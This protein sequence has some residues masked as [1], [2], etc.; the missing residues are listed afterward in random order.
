MD[1]KF[2][3]IDLAK[4]KYT[5][6]RQVLDAKLHRDAETWSVA[7]SGSPLTA[8]LGPLSDHAYVCGSCHH[9]QDDEAYDPNLLVATPRETE[10]PLLKQELDNTTLQ[11]IIARIMERAQFIAED[12][13][14]SGY[15]SLKSSPNYRYQPEQIGFQPLVLPPPHHYQSAR[16]QEL[17]FQPLYQEN[18]LLSAPQVLSAP[19]NQSTLYRNHFESKPLRLYRNYGSGRFSRKPLI[20]ALA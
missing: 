4:I 13:L 8:G 17:P 3:S 5:L 15:S 11:E 20:N 18:H 9:L 14:S 6:K 10:S 19:G 2:T 12:D 1:C 7:D 16:I